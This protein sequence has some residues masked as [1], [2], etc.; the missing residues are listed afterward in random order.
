MAVESNTY[1][2]YSAA[3]EENYPLISNFSHWL[4]P[5][6]ARTLYDVNPVE[7]DFFD[8]MKMGLMRKVRAEE[9]FHREA[10]SRFDTPRVNSSSTQGNVY[11]TAAG[12]DPA[13]FVG[14]PYI[15]LHPDSHS[16]ASGPLAGK[17]SSPRVGEHILFKNL[18]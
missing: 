16:P 6:R 7:A 10:N 1:N 14:M 8:F 18:S 17:T 15:Q 4:E 9:I 5:D 2:D 13:E 12:G 3:T 11:G